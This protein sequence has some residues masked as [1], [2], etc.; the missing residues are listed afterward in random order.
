MHE[1]LRGK[2]LFA[3][4]LLLSVEATAQQNTFGMHTAAFRVGWID[5]VYTGSAQNNDPFNFRGMGVGL[6]YAG[7]QVRGDAFFAR[8]F[9]DL[10]AMIWILPRFARV[11]RRK[12]MIAMPIGLLAAWRRISSAGSSAP[13]RVNAILLGAGGILMHSVAR[14]AK[15]ELRAMPLAGITGS[16][17]ADAVGISWAADAEARLLIS[18]FFS[19]FGL[20]V[21][22]TFRYHFW[23]VNGS[24]VISNAV[25]ELYDYAGTVHTFSVGGQF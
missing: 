23:N 12:T 1:L 3:L 17:V 5:H 22:Y 14:R 25:D 9:L 10:S 8:R 13:Y 16:Q 11:E 18:E 21:G 19:G 6:S 20:T 7:P 2:L 24:R 15:I 4:W